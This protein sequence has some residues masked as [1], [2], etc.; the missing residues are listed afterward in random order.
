[1][2]S[3]SRNWFL[4]LCHSKNQIFEV[5][6]MG[7]LLRTMLS[8]ACVLAIVPSLMADDGPD[9]NAKENADECAAAG[10]WVRFVSL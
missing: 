8:A 1:M 2:P 10:F 6:K 5:S 3:S 7:F 9:A 4:L